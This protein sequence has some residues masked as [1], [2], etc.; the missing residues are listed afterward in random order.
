MFQIPIITTFSLK[1]AT[2]IVEMGSMGFKI[3][4]VKDSTQ[5]SRTKIEAHHLKGKA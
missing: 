2:T 1:T 5:T 4:K 3:I